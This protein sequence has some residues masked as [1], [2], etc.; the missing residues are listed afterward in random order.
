MTLRQLRQFVTPAE[1]GNFRRAAARLHMAQLGG[2][3]G[4]NEGSAGRAMDRAVDSTGRSD[5]N[6]ASLSAPEES[7]CPHPPALPTRP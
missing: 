2:D 5:N 7:P 6:R 3:A 1:T 4:V